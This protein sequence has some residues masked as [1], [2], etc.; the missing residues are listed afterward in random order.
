MWPKIKVK[1]VKCMWPHFADDQV[2][3]ADDEDGL[4]CMISKLK[5]SQQ[6]TGSTISTKNKFGTP[7]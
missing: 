4:S 2:I 5:E 7:N 6:E 1:D 3:I